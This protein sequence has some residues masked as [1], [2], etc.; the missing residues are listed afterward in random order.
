MK[1]LIVEDQLQMVD[2]LTTYL[3]RSGYVCEVATNYEKAEEKIAVYTY[4]CILLD[5]SLPGG[6]GLNLLTLLRKQ[7]TNTGVIILSA[8]DS[9]DDRITGL[10]QGADD[11]LPKPFHLSEL[12]ARLQAL[13]RR[14]KF[15]GNHSVCFENMEIDIESQKVHINATELVL[16]KKEYEL[17]L[18]FASNPERVLSKT[19]LAEH[20]WGDNSDQSDS[21]DFLYSQIKNLRR[22]LSEASA[23][24]TIHA[25]YGLGYK[26]FRE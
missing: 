3:E 14:L 18:F 8:K 2:T 5:I 15:E 19:A 13:F 23:L 25:V 24:F 11:Y 9:V 16:T 12:N 20:I 6:N 26:L 21:F 7:R 17:L 1:I 22:K 4:D 10:Q